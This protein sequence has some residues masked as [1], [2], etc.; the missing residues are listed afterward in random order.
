M[1][2]L[3]KTW[4]LILDSFRI[5]SDARSS[6]MAA[7]LT[8]YTMLSL[9]PTLMIAIAIA[10]YLFDNQLAETEILALFQRYTTDEIAQTVAG[11]ID[12]A[13][14][15][16]SG[17]LAGAISIGILVMGAS[18]AFT[19]VYDT[20]N[21]IWDVDG[22]KKPWLYNIQ[23]RLIGIVMVLLVGILLIAALISN[24]VLG[25]LHHLMEGSPIV[26][27]WLNLIDRSLSYLLMPVVFTLLFAWL[28]ATRV[29]MLDVLPAGVLTA[30]LVAG[31]RYIIQLYLKLSTTSEVYGVAGSLVVLLIW[32]YITGMAVFLGAAFGRA[33]TRLFG[34]QSE[35]VDSVDSETAPLPPAT[36]PESKPEKPHAATATDPPARGTALPYSNPS[37][38]EVPPLVPKRRET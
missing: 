3:K 32:I 25:Y 38:V 28:P 12:R 4:Q 26:L 22:A 21:H 2:L 27:H 5:W 6:Q 13:R 15:P 24:S 9:A 30:L 17:Y 11:L 36:P 20:L 16:Q 37:A 31:G 23:K 19:Q 1:R 34:S 18:G 35:G 7:A 14:H 33:W 8:Y 10:G 29:R